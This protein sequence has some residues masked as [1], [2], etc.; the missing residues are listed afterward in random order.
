MIDPDYAAMPPLMA[1]AVELLLGELARGVAEDPPGSNRGEAV[2]RYLRG[3]RG[4]G[5][6]LIKY[7][8]QG[9]TAADGWHGAP[10]CARFCLWGVEGAGADLGTAPPCA[11]W[12]GLASGLKWLD[13]ADGNGRRADSPAPG[14]VGVVHTGTTWHTVI[15]ARVEGERVWS[16]EGNHGDRVAWVERAAGVFTGFVDLG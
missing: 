13:R 15:I 12:G 4:D 7:S 9:V 10:W 6:W 5:E 2:D 3:R 1:R 8:R 16:I 14:R 11:G